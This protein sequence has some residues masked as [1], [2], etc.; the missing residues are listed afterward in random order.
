MVSVG[1]SVRSYIC[2]DLLCTRIGG[3]SKGGAFAPS[4]ST[5]GDRPLRRSAVIVERRDVLMSFSWLKLLSLSQDVMGRV[6]AS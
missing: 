6:S 2:A 5:T 4:E 1:R 3:P